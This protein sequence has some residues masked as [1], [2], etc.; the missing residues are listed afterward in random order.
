ME[1]IRVTLRF[2]VLTEMEMSI[3]VF[4]VVTQCRVEHLKTE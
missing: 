2:V 3:V 4:C 1:T